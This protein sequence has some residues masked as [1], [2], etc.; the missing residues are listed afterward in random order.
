MRGFSVFGL[1]V[2]AATLVAT[3]AACP[4]SF[5]EITT[6]PYTSPSQVTTNAPQI[7]LA[8]DFLPAT[9]RGRWFYVNPSVY[10]SNQTFYVS[11][12][13]AVTNFD[14][15]IQGYEATSSQCI[16][17]G[18]GSPVCSQTLQ[19]DGLDGNCETLQ[20]NP[21]SALFYWIYVTGYQSANGTFTISVSYTR[22]RTCFA[23][24]TTFSGTSTGT[25]SRNTA[26]GG[27]QIFPPCDFLPNAQVGHWYTYAG[28]G[29]NVRM[30][31]CP[32]TGQDA[33]VTVF[34]RS[35]NCNN[36]GCYTCETP[37][38]AGAAGVCETLNVLSYANEPLYWFVSSVSPTTNVSYTYSYTRTTPPPVASTS[39][40]CVQRASTIQVDV[41]VFRT[42]SSTSLSDFS[43][44]LC[45][46]TSTTV[47]GSWFRISDISGVY[48]L[49][50]CGSQTTIDSKISVFSAA[51][52]SGCSSCGCLT[53]VGSNDDVSRIDYPSDVCSAY[54][55]VYTLNADPTR[56][57]FI[58]VGAATSS[59]S[60][61]SFQFKLSRDPPTASF[62]SSIN[63][64][65]WDAF[66]RLLLA[67]CVAIVFSNM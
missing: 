60:S 4:Q 2:L 50:T 43:S 28:D 63:L 12:C 51:S 10:S 48:F 36:C 14:T 21:N 47:R 18:P 29:F 55:S 41:P 35:N 25:I 16:S 27:T 39:T 45:S 30:S 62:A 19:A 40:T 33:R 24:V 5:E 17:S 61:G 53:C 57:Y 34:R 15:V 22:P 56:T 32:S 38:D 9:A 44:S 59:T 1:V 8:C 7:E 11:T 3:V 31:I 58:F 67:L 13:T 52:S 49:S 65:A 42:L 26:V 64:S 54:A 23:G 6:V 46:I 20:I 66:V 37:V